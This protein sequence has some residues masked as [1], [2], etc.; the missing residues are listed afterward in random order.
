MPQE[1]TAGGEAI[2]IDERDIQNLM[3]T[4]A[5]V[6][7]ACALMLKSVGLG[8]DA[9]SEVLVAGG[10]GRFLDLERSIAIGLLPDLPQGN[11]N[12]AVPDSHPGRGLVDQVDG[13]IRQEA[14]GYIA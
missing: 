11:R 10:F 3:R 1:D 7:S 14:V 8:F 5:A 4:K 9:I 12:G 6:H 13:F 2:V